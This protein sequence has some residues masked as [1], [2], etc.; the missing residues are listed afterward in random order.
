MSIASEITRIKNNIEDAY[1]ECENKGA[2]LPQE[3]NS[4]NLATTIASISSGGGDLSEYFKTEF[5]GNMTSSGNGICATLIKKIPDI[6]IKSASAAD[7]L[8]QGWNNKILIVPHI[9]TQYPITRMA[10]SFSNVKA[11]TSS[12]NNQVSLDLTNIFD[13]SN[14][15]SF[16]GCFQN[17]SFNKIIGLDKLKTNNATNF[18]QMFYNTSLEYLEGDLDFSGFDT[19][20]ATDMSSM[21]SNILIKKID[22]STFNTSNVTNIKNMFYN[23]NISELNVSSFDTSNVTAMN[24]MFYLNTSSNVKELDLSSF[25]LKTNVSMDNMFRDARKIAILDISN[26]DFSTTISSNNN[27]FYNTG[28]NCLQSDGAYADGIPYIYV[29]DAVAQNYILGLTGNKRP[30]S[31]TTANVVIKSN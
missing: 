18:S 16:Q 4:D 6:T 29:K 24:N 7:S 23:A 31:W 19:S 11:G 3:Q 22:L 21:F 20:K 13:T 30:A 17:S 27:L 1:T 12:G 9:T 26:M 28:I 10:G 15:T 5:S 2:T 8:F 25:T 14:V